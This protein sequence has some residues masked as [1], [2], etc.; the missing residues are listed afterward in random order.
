VRA[1]KIAFLIISFMS[2]AQA[3]DGV[4]LGYITGNSYLKFSKVESNAWVVGVMDGIMAE[5]FSIKKDQNGS[6][7]GRCIEGIPIEQIKAMFEQELQSKPE[8]W[9]A[10]AALVF[11][12]RLEKFCQGRK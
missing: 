5:N 7:L 10:P 6:W 4:A 3:Q 1:L 12:S 11:R 9:H 2:C 8:V